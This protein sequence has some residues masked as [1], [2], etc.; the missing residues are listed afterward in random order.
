MLTPSLAVAYL[1]TKFWRNLVVLTTPQKKHK[2]VGEIFGI[3]ESGSVNYAA[4]VELN[5]WFVFNHTY[6]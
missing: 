4:N 5:I 3:V 1:R 2:K 6:S